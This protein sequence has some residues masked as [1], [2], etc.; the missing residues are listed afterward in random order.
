MTTE[1][2]LEESKKAAEADA[3]G[4]A[5]AQKEQTPADESVPVHVELDPRHSGCYSNNTKALAEAKEAAALAEAEKAK[6]ARAKAKAE[7][8]RAEAKRA[9]EAAEAKAKA[10]EEVLAEAV[11]KVEEEQAQAE[12]KEASEASEVE[13]VEKKPSEAPPEDTATVPLTSAAAEPATNAPLTAPAPLC[14]SSAPPTEP[15]P[16]ATCTVPPARPSSV[17]SPPD[18]SSDGALLPGVS[19]SGDAVLVPPPPRLATIRLAPWAKLDEKAF[20][21]AAPNVARSVKILHVG[22]SGACPHRFYNEFVELT[23][24]SESPLFRDAKLR[25]MGHA[26]SPAEHAEELD[27]KQAEFESMNRI[28]KLFYAWRP[29]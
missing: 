15:A 6:T 20:A 23:L 4:R 18:S 22:A 1:K 9:K 19:R 3:Q 13:K 21:L 17:A 2:Q 5:A 24:H 16:P 29:W 14:S 10:E 12:K 8:A 7:E 25:S 28:E 11:K 27:R 26:A